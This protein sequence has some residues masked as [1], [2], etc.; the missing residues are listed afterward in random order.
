[1]QTKY[2]RNQYF[3]EH[4]STISPKQIYFEDSDKFIHY[5]SIESTLSNLMKQPSIAEAVL[6]SNEAMEQNCNGV[7]TDFYNGNIYRKKQQQHHYHR[8]VL[9]L[10][11]YQDCFEIVNPLGSRKRVYKM[12]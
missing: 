12:L 4:F 9:N 1:M 2:L 7:F 8:N 6:S 11:L 10:M 3:K 5:V